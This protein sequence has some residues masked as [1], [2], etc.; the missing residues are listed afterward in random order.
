MW[1]AWSPIGIRSNKKRCSWRQAPRLDRLV[2]RGRA[3]SAGRQTTSVDSA[4]HPA[5]VHHPPNSDTVRRRPATVVVAIVA[6]AATTAA[7]THPPIRRIDYI[8]HY[9]IIV[10]SPL[11]LIAILRDQD[12]ND[13]ATRESLVKRSSVGA[14]QLFSRSR[15]NVS[16]DE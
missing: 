4:V 5:T 8:L 14:R 6:V 15:L 12:A 11:T 7:A 13:F 3:G 9:N 2:G 1:T 10:H 16:S